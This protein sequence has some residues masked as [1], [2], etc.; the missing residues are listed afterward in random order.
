MKK[1]KD[2]FYCRYAKRILDIICALAAMTVFCWLY[3]LIAILV[4]VKLGSPVIFSQ[5]RPGKDEMIFKLYKF[6]TMKDLKDSCGMLLPDDERL[7][8]FGRLLR[9][10]S[11]DELPEAWNILKGDMSVVGPRPL[12]VE[13]LP[14][15]TEEERHRHDIRPGLS[16]LAQINGRNIISW[17]ERFLWDIKYVQ[18]VS[19]FLDVGIVVRSVRLAI[20]RSNI[21][22][23]SEYIIKNLND[24]REMDNADP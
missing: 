13:Y 21:V 24:E 15:Y 12:L 1:G 19:F 10:T 16:G 7:T 9:T 22:V 5:E 8:R 20:K 6:R 3:A 17:G 11:L 14:Y 23:G 4:R 2:G 18:E